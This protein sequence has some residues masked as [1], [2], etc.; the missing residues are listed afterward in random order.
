MGHV[1]CDSTSST[2]CCTASTDAA[3][4]A[5]LVLWLWS[6]LVSELNVNTARLFA[7]LRSTV[8]RFH[9][10]VSESTAERVKE[11]RFMLVHV[12]WCS[13]GWVLKAKMLHLTPKIH[14]R[15]YQLL[16]LDL[17]F[18]TSLKHRQ[19]LF[20][21][22]ILVI[23]CNLSLT[24]EMLGLTLPIFGQRLEGRRNAMYWYWFLFNL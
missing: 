7:Q 5:C 4:P 8:W 3:K 9:T 18:C 21:N 14:I 15:W 23:C 19:C 2:C 12:I 6:M 20:P 22:M 24:Q 17:L 13:A 16:T 10:F 11:E 1:L